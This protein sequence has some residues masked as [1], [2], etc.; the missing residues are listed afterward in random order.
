MTPGIP[1]PRWVSYYM[2]A[3]VFTLDESRLDEVMATDLVLTRTNRLPDYFPADSL[4]QPV[5]SQGRYRLIS[6]DRLIG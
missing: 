3:P 2:D 5:A 1:T 4:D 6:A